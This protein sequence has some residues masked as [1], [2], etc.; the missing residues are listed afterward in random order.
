MPSP[1]VRETALCALGCP[2]ICP[3]APGRTRVMPARTAAITEGGSPAALME[4]PIAERLSAVPGHPR[5]S[6]A[7]AVGDENWSRRS[8]L[9]L[10]ITKKPSEPNSRTYQHVTF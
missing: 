9:N 1:K 3:E 7:V 6:G 10:L 4:A 2:S 5:G 8:G